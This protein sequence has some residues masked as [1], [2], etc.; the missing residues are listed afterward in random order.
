MNV[1]ER[2]TRRVTGLR[3]AASMLPILA[4]LAVAGCNSVGDFG[5]GSVTAQ[6]INPSDPP[7]KIE[8]AAEY[9]TKRFADDPKDKTAAIN[10]SVAM[11]ALNK[12]L[13]AVLVMRQAQEFHPNDPEILGELGKALADAGQLQE[14]AGILDQAQKSGTADWRMLSAYGT[15]LDQLQRHKEAQASYM[16]ALKLV[17]NEPSV[18]NNLGLSYALDKKLAEAETIL[19]KA[20]A[21]PAAP[22]QAKEN[23]AL[24]LGLQGKFGEAEAVAK[25]TL[26][27]DAVASNTSYLKQMMAQ[28]AN[29]AKLQAMEAKETTGSTN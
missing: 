10:V 27:P 19:R 3:A 6:A 22:Q 25:S 8:A 7:A 20:A 12:K 18:M 4:A 21:H 9:W 5:K 17:P 1:H 26:P 14:A 15:V 28:P 2:T 16:E 23:L 11:R 24:V 29:W 13:S